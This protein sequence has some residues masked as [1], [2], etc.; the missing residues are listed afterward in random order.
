MRLYEVSFLVKAYHEGGRDESKCQVPSC[1][2]ARGPAMESEGKAKGS[3]ITA[4][5]S[6][7]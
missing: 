3:Q 4:S 6:A 5:M 1:K 7:E 2:A